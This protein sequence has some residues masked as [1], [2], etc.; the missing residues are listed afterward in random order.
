M[1]IDDQITEIEY[2]SRSLKAA[3]V[4]R[5]EAASA[6]FAGA[7][8]FALIVALAAVVAR[9]SVPDR[10]VYDGPSFGSL[11]LTG[12]A[13]PYIIIGSLAFLLGISFTLLCIHVRDRNRGRK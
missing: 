13:L 6:V 9:A 3:R 1:S 8:C 12:P 5:R 2:R 4:R 7:A 10:Q 11:V